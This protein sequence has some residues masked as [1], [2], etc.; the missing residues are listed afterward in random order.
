MF[1][2]KLGLALTLLAC[3]VIVAPVSASAIT[4]VPFTP[5]ANQAS[6][7][8]P[9]F[10]PGTTCV[11]YD[12]SHPWVNGKNFYVGNISPHIW[13][14]I[15]LKSGTVNDIFVAGVDFNLGDTIH[16]VSG[17]NISHVIKCWTTTQVTTTTTEKV[18][19]TTDAPTTSTTRGS[20]TTTLD[21]GTTTTTSGGDTTT[22]TIDDGTTTTSSSTTTV[23]EQPTTTVPSTSTSVA[24]STST[25]KPSSSTSSTSTPNLVK[26][27][28]KTGSDSSI[29]LLYGFLLLFVGQL[30][31]LR[32]RR[33]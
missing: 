22:T 6:Y 32:G 23:V 30:L 19:T 10:G 14:G 17:K 15:I 28:P 31:V 4:S 16:T 11:K 25:S 13:V 33:D 12:S 18:T 29:L 9:Y 7:W 3:V 8:E 24:V 2:R 5:E 27:L 21:G 1:L 20:T 26:E